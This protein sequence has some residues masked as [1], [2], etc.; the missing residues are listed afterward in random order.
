MGTALKVVGGLLL[1]GVTLVFAVVGIY[2]GYQSYVAFKAGAILE[3]IYLV[4]AA[5]IFLRK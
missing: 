3:A 4:V 1:L 2:L 5:S